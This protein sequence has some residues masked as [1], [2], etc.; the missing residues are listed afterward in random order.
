MRESE[1]LI[2]EAKQVVT[3]SL[4]RCNEHNITYW[5]RIKSNIRDDLSEFIW[6]RMKRRPMIL[7]IIM[8][9]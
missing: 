3:I 8:E 9:V 5:N 2:Q 4:E 1:D 6:K 7:P